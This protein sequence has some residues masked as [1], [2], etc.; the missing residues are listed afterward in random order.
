MKNTQ[1]SLKK[2]LKIIIMLLFLNRTAK[3]NLIRDNFFFKKKLL[4]KLM[5]FS[6]SPILYIIGEPKNSKKEDE[7][8][9]REVMETTN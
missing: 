1:I 4:Y 7:M 5:V 3:N 6:L 8:I 9:K 2:V